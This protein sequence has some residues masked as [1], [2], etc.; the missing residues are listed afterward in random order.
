MQEN[1]IFLG[2]S[3][4]I[5]ICNPIS[6]SS[7]VGRARPC[8]GRGREFESRLPLQIPLQ[9]GFFIDTHERSLAV[10]VRTKNVLF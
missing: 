10:Q 6:G 7:S 9:G 1:Q 8:Q 3:D 2:C 5:Y 4:F